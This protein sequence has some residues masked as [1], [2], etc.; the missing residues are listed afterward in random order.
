MCPS[1]EH[2]RFTVYWWTHSI[3]FV[4][5]H[6]V[7]LTQAFKNV[8]LWN[9]DSVLNSKETT[10][11]WGIDWK[12]WR[13]RSDCRRIELPSRDSN[14]KDSVWKSSFWVIGRLY[15]LDVQRVVEERAYHLITWD[16]S[17]SQRHFSFQVLAE[18]WHENEP[19][20]CD[21]Q[22][23]IQKQELFFFQMDLNRKSPLPWRLGSRDPWEE[24]T[25]RN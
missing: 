23:T 14:E 21:R 19:L 25:K 4:L 8:S 7:L 10:L 11:D 5:S 1:L 18:P 20:C 6:Q 22:D 24:V 9:F 12:L 13:R 16:V 17:A 3:I 15:S 2:Q